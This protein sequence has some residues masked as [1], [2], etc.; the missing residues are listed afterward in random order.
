VPRELFV[1]PS[2]AKV[3]YS[4]AVLRIKAGETQRTLLVPMV[5]ARMLQGAGLKPTDRALDVGGGFGY[6]AAI[7]SRLVGSVTMLES[8]VGF[9]SAARP[10]FTDLGA[11]SI[12]AVT[13][14]LEMGWA[15]AAPYDLILING[16]VETGFEGL[17][18]QL[19][20]GGRLVAV[21]RELGQTGRASK[22]KRFEKLA[23]GAIGEKWLFDAAAEPLAPFRRAAAFAF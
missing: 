12:A 22:A 20:P 11:A 4:D 7:L 14:P 1:G 23:N 6:S 10:A 15:A 5:L 21:V 18:G 8:D 2:N 17:L 16:A 3:A 9:T 13:G 19:A